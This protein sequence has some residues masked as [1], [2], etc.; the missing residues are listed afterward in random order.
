[1]EKGDMDYRLSGRVSA[2]QSADTKAPLRVAGGNDLTMPT[3]TE[4]QT[5][6]I[7]FS[8]LHLYAHCFLARC[9]V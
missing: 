5:L 9:L 6:L 7:T 8:L 4:S 2:V 1:M 3:S